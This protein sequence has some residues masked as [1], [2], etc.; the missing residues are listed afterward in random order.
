[1]NEKDGEITTP[2]PRSRSAAE[3]ARVRVRNGVKAVQDGGPA[4][5]L[6]VHTAVQARPRAGLRPGEVVAGHYRILERVARGGSAIVYR[7]WHQGLQ[8]PVA[9]KVLILNGGADD[10]DFEARFVREARAMLALHHENIVEVVDFGRL[11]DGRCFLATEFLDGLRLT[12]VFKDS[13]VDAPTRLELLAQ[14][15]DGLAH[16]HAQGI[17]HRDIKLSNVMVVPAGPRPRARILDFGLARLMDEDQELTRH[18]VVMGSPHFMSPEQARGQEL[19]PRT[20]VYSLGVLAW[21]AFTGCFPY[22][23]P[24]P[25]ATMVQHCV[26]PVPLLSHARLL[27]PIPP[28]LAAVVARCMAKDPAA[29][30]PRMEELAQAFRQAADDVR[31]GAFVGLQTP[32][33]VALPAPANRPP[34]PAPTRL[35]LLGCLLISAACLWWQEEGLV[36]PPWVTPQLA[37]R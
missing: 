26:E 4:P 6:R 16:A 19:D 5:S 18:G 24:T 33:A 28:G 17:I 10:P 20:D 11:E 9:L 21:V 22:S 29:R 30:Y 2:I 13:S 12:D 23:G 8:R 35:A 3:A 32:Q 7:A 27:L 1:M 25:T 15:A 34:A 31:R 36:P 37:M 14:I